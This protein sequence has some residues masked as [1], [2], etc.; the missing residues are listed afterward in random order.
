VAGDGVAPTD[1]V[2]AFV[3]LA[4]QADMGEVGFEQ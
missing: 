2:D 4:F 3:R 1:G